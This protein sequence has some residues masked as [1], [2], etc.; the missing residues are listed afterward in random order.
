MGKNNHRKNQKSYIRSPRQGG[1][2]TA[3]CIANFPALGELQILAEGGFSHLFK[4]GKGSRLYDMDGNRFFDFVLDEGRK[5][6]GHAPPF[7]THS[8]KNAVSRGQLDNCLSLEFYRFYSVL[9][10]RCPEVDDYELFFLSDRRAP[11]ALLRSVFS[12]WEPLIPEQL[13]K[14]GDSTRLEKRAKSLVSGGGLLLLD[15]S[16]VSFFDGSQLWIGRMRPEAAALSFCGIHL[17]LLRPGH[18]LMP[19]AYLPA[20]PVLA[21]ATAFL[22]NLT[23]PQEPFTAIEEYSR[24]FESVCGAHISGWAGFSPKIRMRDVQRQELRKRGFLLSKTGYV[25]FSSAHDLHQVR[26]LADSINDLF[27]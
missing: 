17:L 14:R 4:R 6:F 24:L 20:L 27:L 5:L 12:G 3:S 2:L 22:K 8:I 9:R 10:N 11:G 15:Q 13:V 7:L 25:H 16:G 19:T 1:G 23:G 26:R 18:G 21:E